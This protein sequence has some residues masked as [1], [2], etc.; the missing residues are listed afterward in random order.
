MFVLFRSGNLETEEMG[1]AVNHPSIPPIILLH[2]EASTKYVSLSDLQQLVNRLPGLYN[3]I[4][5][6]TSAR[7]QKHGPRDSSYTDASFQYL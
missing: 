4:H 1:P 5:T 7:I 6:R 3:V 2:G